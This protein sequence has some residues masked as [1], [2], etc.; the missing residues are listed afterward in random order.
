MEAN[1]IIEGYTTRLN[2]DRLGRPVGAYILITV[3]YEILKEQKTTQQQL[4]GRL[5][6]LGNVEEV[7]IIAGEKDLIVKV[8]T[9]SIQKLSD[10]VT[11]DIR[12]IDGIEKTI[13][14]IVLER[15]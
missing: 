6:S 9:E 8:Q 11:K 7:C 4:A 15:I 1:G 5:K 14:M 13:T 10:I 2:Y 12:N 3:D